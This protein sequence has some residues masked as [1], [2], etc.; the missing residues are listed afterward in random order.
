[1]LCILCGRTCTSRPPSS[2]ITTSCITPAPAT[3]KAK[4][5]SRTLTRKEYIVAMKLYYALTILVCA[6]TARAIEIDYNERLTSDSDLVSVAADQFPSWKLVLLTEAA[7]TT[8]AVCLD[9]TA[10]G[11]YIER[12][13]GTGADKWMPVTILHHNVTAQCGRPND[14][15]MGICLCWD[16]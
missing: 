4:L 10:P 14:L 2:T 9:G 5:A 7:R 1:M 12:G 16:R 15:C 13:S 3:H 6:G 11:Y 8:G